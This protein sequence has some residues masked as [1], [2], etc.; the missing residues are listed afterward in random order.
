[1]DKDKDE[2]IC[3]KNGD[4]DADGDTKLINKTI[5]IINPIIIIP[6]PSPYCNEKW[7]Y[8]NFG[9]DW[10]CDCKEGKEQSPIDLSKI[11]DMIK[12]NIFPIF[13]YN[14]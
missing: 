3:M 7:N 12:T 8:K 1:M 11:E 10:E 4:S 5:E 2:D 9:D 6:R 14:K 13:R